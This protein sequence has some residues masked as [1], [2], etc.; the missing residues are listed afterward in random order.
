MTTRIDVK[1]LPRDV[2]ELIDAGEDLVITRNGETIATIAT[3]VRTNGAFDVGPGTDDTYDVTVVATTMKLSPAARTALSEQLGP[4]YIVLDMHSAPTTADVVL[5]PPAS[6]QL[7]GALRET[8]PKARIVVAEIED[9]VLG[10]RYEGPVR[11]L[12]DAGAETY[13]A[14]TTIHRLATQLDHVVTQQRQQLAAGGP[15]QLEIEA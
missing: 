5:V 14:S 3:V 4:D 6:P 7:I 1:R 15:A 12:I 11:R 13:L 8:Y 9:P 2:V 10:I